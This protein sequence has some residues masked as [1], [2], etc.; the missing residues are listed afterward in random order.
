MWVEYNKGDKFFELEF[1][2]L[3]N[4][5]NLAMLVIDDGQIDRQSQWRHF[6]QIRILFV[7][8]ITMSTV[9]KIME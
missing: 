7:A 2:T 8:E 3:L 9:V 6:H 1:Q 4:K 5:K